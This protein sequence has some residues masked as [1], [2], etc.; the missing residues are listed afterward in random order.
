MT[1]ALSASVPAQLAIAD[2][3]EHGGYDR[4]LRKLRLDLARL[5]AQMLRAIR[6]YFPL[7]TSVVKPDGGYFLW[8]ELP[9]HVDAVHLFEVA[10][11]HDIAIAPG[12]IFSAAGDLRRYIR[13]N[14]GHP[15]TPAVEG[16][17]RTIGALVCRALPPSGLRVT[18]QQIKR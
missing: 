3:L 16:A 8:V 2:Y 9:P 7:G 6:D 5:Q 12:P 17:I 11:A 4:F 1:A 13:L 10:L 15:W 14:Y 18:L